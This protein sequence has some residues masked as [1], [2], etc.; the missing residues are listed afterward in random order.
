MEASK[1]MDWAWKVFT[2]FVGLALVPL[3]GWIWSTQ[4]QVTKLESTVGYQDR[5]ISELKDDLEKEQEKVGV[6]MT[7]NTDV[8]WI[9]K[10]LDDVDGTLKRIEDR[11]AELASAL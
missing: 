1:M 9:K 8:S 3:G 6:L 10:E 4:G 11:V 5:E 7:T 2:L